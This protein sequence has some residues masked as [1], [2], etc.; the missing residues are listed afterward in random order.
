MLP[1]Y[2]KTAS[3][4]AAAAILAPLAIVFIALPAGAICIVL[5]G[6]RV[7]KRLRDPRR[8][9]WKRWEAERQANRHLP[10]T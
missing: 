6:I 1:S 5:E 3:N 4:I 9:Q 8:A 2:I 7:I 10:P